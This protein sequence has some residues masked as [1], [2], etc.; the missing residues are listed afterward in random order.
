MDISLGLL[1]DIIAMY[2]SMISYLY[3]L[4]HKITFVSLK[5]LKIAI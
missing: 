4:F 5:M 2:I 3:L 1:L